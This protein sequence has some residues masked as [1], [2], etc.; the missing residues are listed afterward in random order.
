[1]ERRYREAPADIEALKEQ[2][3]RQSEIEI[4]TEDL[5]RQADVE[6]PK[7]RAFGSSTAEPSDEE[8]WQAY[9]ELQDGTA[10]RRRSIENARREQQEREE[11][12]VE[13]CKHTGSPLPTH[14]EHLRP[15]LREYGY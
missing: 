11:E 9:V 4:R 13:Y 15:R 1:M 7:E 12:L 14:M 10:N 2:A 6:V 5:R 3:R 8:I